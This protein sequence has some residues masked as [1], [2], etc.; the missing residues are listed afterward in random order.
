MT[1]GCLLPWWIDH[2]PLVGYG[3]GR[4]LKKGSEHEV[5]VEEPLAIISIIQYF[6]SKGHTLEGSIRDRLQD[7]QGMALEEAVLLA[8]TRLLQGKRML[9]SIFEFCRPSPPWAR[10]EAQI[11]ARGTSGK[12]QP[13]SIDD[14]SSISSALA[15]N[16]QTMEDVAHW[17]REGKEAWC[18]PGNLMGPD[19][20]ARVKL[21]NGKFLLLVIQG[22][23]HT[24]GSEHLRATVAADA[25]RSLDP[26][27]Y[28]WS[29]VRD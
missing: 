18:I 12:F 17:L 21:D 20:M 16:A 10:C 11:V 6:R 23:C 5:A 1:R 15:C 4:F 24:T 2:K 27:R 14:P 28:F 9:K 29:V 8:L 7:K 25:I 3:I 22:K 19:L 26:S 13:F